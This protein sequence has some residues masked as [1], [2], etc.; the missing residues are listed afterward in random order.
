MPLNVRNIVVVLAATLMVA[1]NNSGSKEPESQS[2]ITIAVIPKGTTHSY[3]KSVEAGARAA[4]KELGAKILWKGPLKEDD[5]AGQIQVV[6]QFVADKVSG[7]VIAPL[8]DQALVGPVQA[9]GQKKIPVVIIDSS[10]KATPGKDFASFVATDNRKAGQLGGERLGQLLNGKGKVV[11]L[12]YM[13]GSA[14]TAD[15]EAGFMDAIKKFPGIQV[16]SS[17]KYGG[18][19]Q[20]EAQTKAMQM[21]DTLKQADGI[22][23]PNES[24]TMGMVQALIQTKLSGKVKFVGFDASSQLI[25][26]LKQGQVDAL[27]AQN[28]VK[29]GYEGV[30]AM[31]ETIKG[32]KVETT[33]DT[34]VT[35]IDKQNL[36]SADVKKLISGQ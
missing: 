18:A 33:I 3:W 15:R 19:S 34:G 32:Q 36:E 5:R 4:G 20:A 13:E 2:S 27:V 31:V 7:I 6:Q 22:F 8:D 30:K 23:T 1:C 35:V 17:D 24:S 12:R 16:I 21:V 10:L 26:A 25:D 28:P 11:L 29:M 14:S 9:A